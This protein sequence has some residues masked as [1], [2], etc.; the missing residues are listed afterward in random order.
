MFFPCEAPDMAEAR[1][2]SKRSTS[3][4]SARASGRRRR[5]Q[6]ERS[7]ETQARLVGA[8]LECLS[9]RGYAGT[10]TLAVCRRAGV[11]HGSLLH[12]FG[13]RERLLGA[14]LD[15]AYARLRALVVSG[16]EA[17]PE[18]EA[19][20]EAMVELM[21]AACSAPEFEAVIELWLAA[22]HQPEVR[23]T[24][25]PGQQAFDA[26]NLPLAERLFPEAAARL[27][28]FP[29]YVSLVFQAMQGMGLVRATLPAS[30][31]AE[32]MRA[33][34]RALLTRVLRQ[35]FAAAAEPASP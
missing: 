33:R 25:W 29:V 12:H 5:T 26:A 11:S 15:A 21:W 18:G 27:P 3:G 24:V 30:P 32:A 13:T 17:L 35:A 9:E 7:A 8:T 10:T 31:E 28:D 22:A 16:L 23:W 20:V 4:R 2:P 1:T 34:V 6:A 19:R 14:A